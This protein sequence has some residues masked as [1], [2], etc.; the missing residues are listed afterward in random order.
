M[1]P[2]MLCL[3]YKYPADTETCRY[4]ISVRQSDAL[5]AQLATGEQTLRGSPDAYMPNR[6][7]TN[8]RRCPKRLPVVRRDLCYWKS[9]SSRSH[10]SFFL[11]F[12][13]R[14]PPSLVP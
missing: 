4:A 7:V 2:C 11:N 12:H 14:L 1:R 3:K 9:R 6:K 13:A 10:G 8:S 5:A